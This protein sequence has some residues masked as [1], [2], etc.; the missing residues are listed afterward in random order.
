M[1]RI[2]IYISVIL[3]LASCGGQRKTVK[4]VPEPSQETPV[5]VTDARDNRFGEK[6]VA[7]ARKWIGTPYKYGGESRKGTDCS[8]LTMVV[9]RDVAGIKI[10]RNSGKQQEFCSRISRNA[11][12]PGDLVFFSSS[13][14]GSV[15]HVGIYAGSGKFIHASSSRGVILS[16]LDEDY[17]RRHFHSAGRV[18]GTQAK[19]GNNS[20]DPDPIVETPAPRPFKFETVNHMPGREAPVVVT[21]TVRIVEVRVD[22]V[23]IPLPSSDEPDSISTEVRNAF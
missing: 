16:S 3:L 7:Q 11:L 22:T 17:Y 18:P 9:Y 6:I 19:T 14:K 1:K 8:G 5:I 21:E 4:P 15:S 2:F 13:R 23:Y 12:S 10:P 20:K